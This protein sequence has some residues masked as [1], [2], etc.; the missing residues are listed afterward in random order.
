MRGNATLAIVLS[1]VC[2]K[3]ASITVMVMRI[4]W[5][6]LAGAAGATCG[7][8]ASWAAGRA[9]ATIGARDVGAAVAAVAVVGVAVAA[10]SAAPDAAG[11]A[12]AADVRDVGAAPAD[13]SRDVSPSVLAA[14][15][16]T[17]LLRARRWWPPG[18]WRWSWH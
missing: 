15:A 8:E 17:S 4:R 5:G 2:M 6:G 1:R 9:G 16:F 12:V 18:N 7:P 3:E 10:G 13:A 14:L 11:V